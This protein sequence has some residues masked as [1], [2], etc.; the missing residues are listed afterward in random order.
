MNQPHTPNIDKPVL[1]SARPIGGSGERL[2]AQHVHLNVTAVQL[3]AGQW[4]WRTE[5]AFS[6]GDHKF[7]HLIAT[8]D[9]SRRAEAMA[10][11]INAAEPWFK[12]TNS[13]GGWDWHQLLRE[14]YAEGKEQRN[15]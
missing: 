10:D 8:A 2:M 12:S 3:S 11:T 14:A 6:V 15:D 7:R 1:F 9:T 5:L 4:E 13:R